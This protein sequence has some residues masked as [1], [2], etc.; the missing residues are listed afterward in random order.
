MMI[1]LCVWFLV[2]VIVGVFFGTFIAVGN[3]DE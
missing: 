1:S 2:G 3:R